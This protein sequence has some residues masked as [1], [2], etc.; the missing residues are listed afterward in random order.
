M[1]DLYIIK[2]LDGNKFNELP[3]EERL[4]LLGSM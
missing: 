1:N 2:A 3:L 4:T